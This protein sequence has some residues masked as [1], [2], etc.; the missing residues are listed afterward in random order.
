VAFSY[1]EGTVALTLFDAGT[2]MELKRVG[3]LP[4]VVEYALSPDGKRV[5]ARQPAISTA[6]GKRFGGEID[7]FDVVT[8]KRIRRLEG[9]DGDSV[10]WSPDG[11]L[12]ASGSIHSS[13]HDTIRLWDPASGEVVRE[14]GTDLGGVR[15]L[16]FLPDGT[17]A[18]GGNS[19]VLT[20]WDASSGK[21][22]RKAYGRIGFVLALSSDGRRFGLHQFDSPVVI[23][24]V[25]SGR[26]LGTY[27]AGSRWFGF[28]LSPDG[29]ALA[30]T[31]NRN[32][33][34]WPVPRLDAE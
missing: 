19:G 12:L 6:M 33:L 34:L 21:Q 17:L 22:L 18:S 14:W 27:A 10:A 32:L 28:A 9:H 1:S 3:G 8:G 26:K 29:K 31:G 7:L 30:T 20:L 24:D 16:T 15:L 25:Q 13:P 2:G 11:K 5:A 4:S 23:R